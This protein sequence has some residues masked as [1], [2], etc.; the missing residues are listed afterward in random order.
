[1]SIPES[2]KN[3]LVGIFIGIFM[4]MPGAS[5][6]TM[7]VVFGVYERLI[8]DAS[9]LWVYL[10]KDIR[11][12][13]LLG[14]GVVLGVVI[15]AKGLDFLIEKYE[16]PLM[17]FFAALIL[18]QLPDIW[19]NAD[20]GEKM[21]P[22]NYLAL[23]GGFAVMMVVLYAGQ[24]GIEQGDSAGALVMLVA[25]V[26]YAICALSPG[27]SG[28]TILLAL[29][30]FAPVIDSLSDLHLSSILPLAVGALIGILLFANLINHC[31]THY[32]KSTYC[33]I[34][35]LTAGSVVTVAG[36]GLLSMEGD[37]LYLQ[38]AVFIVAGLI[39]GWGIHLFSNYVQKQP[40]EEPQE[41]L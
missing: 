41:D 9:K 37:D 18:V 27:I 20:D 25:G 32:R 1:M 13:V 6:A 35:G 5:G 12:L 2:A 7:A 30:L 15:C 8:R 17:F 38:I 34:L 4:L 19:K 40:E 29:G 39:I 23:I 31:V 21:R 22:T 11:F 26:I 3:F 14:I 33:A 24:L 10:I 28:S 36:N 16:I